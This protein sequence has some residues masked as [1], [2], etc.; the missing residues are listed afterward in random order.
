MDKKITLLAIVIA[1]AVVATG[2]AVVLSNQSDEPTPCVR[3][4]AVGSGY[5]DSEHELV[6]LHFTAKM[7]GM[8]KGQRV[9][10]TGGPDLHVIDYDR[11]IG[12]LH[13]MD[14]SIEIKGS[15]YLY[16]VKYDLRSLENFDEEVWSLRYALDY[17]VVP[18]TYPDSWTRWLVK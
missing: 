11:V 14:G 10:V 13:P 16:K 3:E 18:G 17:E 7:N 6:C 9:I 2:A 8:E 15:Q 1:V 5:F 12:T 4:Y